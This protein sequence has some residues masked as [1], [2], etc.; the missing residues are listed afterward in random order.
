[1]G[2]ANTSHSF[3]RYD[4]PHTN[5]EAGVQLQ[6]WMYQGSD[7]ARAQLQSRGRN[8]IWWDQ[9]AKQVSVSKVCSKANK[10]LVIS[11]YVLLGF[12]VY[13]RSVPH[14]YTTPTNSMIPVVIDTRIVHKGMVCTYGTTVCRIHVYQ[15]YR[16]YD[17]HVRLLVEKSETPVSGRRLRAWKET[18]VPNRRASSSSDTLF[19]TPN[20]R[21]I[22]HF[23]YR[24]FL[25][26][27]ADRFGGYFPI[28][29]Q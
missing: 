1:M 21:L 23:T 19:S 13:A 9:Y 3:L 26:S 12:S 16:W 4:H 22:S 11:V 2:W 8:Q 10:V 25:L 18:E 7:C 27:C 14:I 15:K 24:S 17:T 28:P 5:T 6:S 29:R 20:T